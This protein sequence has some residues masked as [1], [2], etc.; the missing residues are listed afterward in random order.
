MSKKLVP[1]TREYLRSHYESLVIDP[2]PAVFGKIRLSATSICT[3]LHVALQSKDPTYTDDLRVDLARTAPKKIDENFFRNREQCERIVVEIIKPA[4]VERL[5]ASP[6]EDVRALAAALSAMRAQMTR[7][8][9]SFERYQKERQASVEELVRKF[10]PNDFRMTLLTKYRERSER[11]NAEALATLRRQ[12]VSVA[13][14]YDTLWAQQLA[15]R[16]TLVQLGQAS[17]A[18]KMFL[19]LLAGVP[20]VLLDF[21]R[22]INDEQGPMEEMRSRYGPFIYRLT[23]LANLVRVTV[24]L[25]VRALAVA[26][27]DDLRVGLRD[28][29]SLLQAADAA[30]AGAVAYYL[31]FMAR[32][33][34][35]SP[36]F[37]EEY[38][39]NPT[40]AAEPVT[41]IVVPAGKTHDVTVDVPVPGW[42]VAWEFETRKNDIGFGVLQ[43]DTVLV[44]IRRVDSHTA[45]I[46][47]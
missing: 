10:L 8:G 41:E 45:R 28:I 11:K 46:E 1:I 21:V 39:G 27:P 43:G 12:G 18:F 34:D 4:T 2:E 3:A 33:W 47:V 36:F 19:R 25:T 35:A 44:P 22:T 32:V 16:A 40:M 29:T 42:T 5:G 30:Y 20:S 17:G 15:R 24:Q 7:V 26:A 13:T 6:H 38:G 9:Q 31:A 23:E 37:M 14:Q